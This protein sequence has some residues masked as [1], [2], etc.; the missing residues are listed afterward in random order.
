[1]VEVICSS[2]KAVR[3]IISSSGEGKT[4]HNLK[5]PQTKKKKQQQQNHHK[6]N[7]KHHNQNEQ[8]PVWFPKVWTDLQSS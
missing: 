8:N 2:R 1:M 5:K 6:T 4:K 7:K 3:E